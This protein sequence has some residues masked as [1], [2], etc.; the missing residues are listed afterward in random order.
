MVDGSPLVREELVLALGALIEAQREYFELI[1]HEHRDSIFATNNGANGA[2]G[3]LLSTSA[4]P[5]PSQLISPHPHTA[6][7]GTPGG[8]QRNLGSTFANSIPNTPS[9]AVTSG[10]AGLSAIARPG[11]DPIASPHQAPMAANHRG[12]LVTSVTGPSPLLSPANASAMQAAGFLT[13][14]TQ[15][16]PLPSPSNSMT[17]P[18]PLHRP[19]STSTS[20]NGTAFSYHQ[21]NSSA[22]TIADSNNAHNQRLYIWRVVRTLCHDPFPAVHKAAMVLRKM[23][24]SRGFTNRK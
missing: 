17:T 10:A 8:A 5:S 2:P 3:S 22:S 13:P 11:N 15:Q 24:Y 7:S 16:R 9:A 4:C 6:S 18:S 12:S 23:M 21:R 14:P 1:A 19:L 20:Q